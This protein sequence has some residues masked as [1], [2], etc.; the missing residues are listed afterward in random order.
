LQKIAAA[1]GQGKSM[2]KGKKKTKQ[3]KQ[4]NL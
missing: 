2:A 4:S 1:K 3:K